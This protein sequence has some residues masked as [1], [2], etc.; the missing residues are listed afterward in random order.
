MSHIFYCFCKFLSVST[1]KGF[2][3]SLSL[4]TYDFN[5]LR[6]VFL[7]QSQYVCLLIT[8]WFLLLDIFRTLR[9]SIPA[10]VTDF[11]RRFVFLLRND[12]CSFYLLIIFCFVILD[13]VLRLLFRH[14]WE[15]QKAFH[16]QLRCIVLIKRFWSAA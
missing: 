3:T 5:V 13:C 12:F 14:E 2:F 1:L 15:V 4:R 7:G 16:F 11:P 8:P 10:F 6:L 9:S